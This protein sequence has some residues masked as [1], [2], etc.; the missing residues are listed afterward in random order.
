[1]LREIAKTANKNMA[2]Y[3]DDKTS[4]I[5]LNEDQDGDRQL[6]FIATSKP[7]KK[8]EFFFIN[9]YSHQLTFS[10]ATPWPANFK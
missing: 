7:T 8:E 5:V 6:L 9:Y 1:M 10:N 3:G 4:I 2:G